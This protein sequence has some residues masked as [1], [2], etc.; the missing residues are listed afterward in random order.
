M[1]PPN[2]TYD[3]THSLYDEKGTELDLSICSRY[4]PR[5]K[6]RASRVV[7]SV[8]LADG[9]HLNEELNQ[10]EETEGLLPTRLAEGSSKS[11]LTWFGES[12]SVHVHIQ[13]SLFI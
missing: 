5:A 6:F 1:E 11:K 10:V 8:L 3:R 7:K 4:Q 12:M 13:I 9:I 2:E